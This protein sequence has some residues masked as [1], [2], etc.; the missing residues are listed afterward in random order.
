MYGGLTLSVISGLDW[1][2]IQKIILL[3][4]TGLQIN[5]HGLSRELSLFHEDWLSICNRTSQSYMLLLLGV[6]CVTPNLVK[7]DPLYDLIPE[8]SNQESIFSQAV[9]IKRVIFFILLIERQAHLPPVCLSASLLIYENFHKYRDQDT[10]L[11]CEEKC[12]ADTI[13]SHV[14]CKE[15][16]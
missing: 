11:Y 16:G 4:N 10:L 8:L 12:H 9:N 2:S 3:L 14:N 1:C 6:S 7:I 15:H 5:A 13:N